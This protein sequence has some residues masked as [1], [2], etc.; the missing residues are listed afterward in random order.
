[1]AGLFTYIISE[2]IKI[3][4]E[5]EQTTQLLTSNAE[6]L[7]VGIAYGNQCLS[8]NLNNHTNIFVHRLSEIL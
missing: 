7:I 6:V 2:D 8:F 4:T 3:D 5:K 1:M